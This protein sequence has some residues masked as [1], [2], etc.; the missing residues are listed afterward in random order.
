MRRR[1]LQVAALVVIVWGVSQMA[2]GAYIHSKA[3][4]AQVL[5]RWAWAKTLT[6]G[7]SPKPW[8]W[9]DTTP[10]AR[11]GAPMHRVE[12]IVLEGGSG[13]SLAFGPGHVSGTPLPGR[14]GNAVIGGHRDTHFRFLKY[15]ER[16]DPLLLESPSGELLDYV[17]TETA[18]V[19]HRR[20][21]VMRDF[22]D[23]RLTLIT[24]YPFDAIEPGGPERYVVTAI[25]VREPAYFAPVTPAS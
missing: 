23:E 21:D 22:G 18:V 13:S 15:L 7:G 11:L 24:C 10:V 4:L 6:K 20:T 14:P 2:R 1:V 9:A 17:V 19:D 12:L 16:G 25:R 8:P 5:I 3:S